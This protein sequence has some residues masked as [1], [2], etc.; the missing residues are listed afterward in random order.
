MDINP[1]NFKNIDGRSILLIG[2]LGNIGKYITDVL[3]QL[4]NYSFL[5]LMDVKTPQEEFK[6][7][8]RNIEAC[9]GAELGNIKNRDLIKASLDGIDTVLFAVGI[10][11]RLGLTKDEKTSL[12][13]TELVGIKNIIESQGREWNV[14]EIIYISSLGAGDTYPVGENTKIKQ[15]VDEILKDEVW[16]RR[17]KTFVSIRPSGYLYDIFEMPRELKKRKMPAYLPKGGE[18]YIQPIAEENVAEMIVRSINNENARNNYIHAAGP[19]KYTYRELFTEFNKV[20]GYKFTIDGTVD[21]GFCIEW[22]GSDVIAH[23]L[24]THSIITDKQ[25]NDLT[26]KYFPGIKLITLEEAVKKHPEYIKIN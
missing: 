12:Y 6:I 9:F 21:A 4:Q 23:R 19:K 2:A 7:P 18:V 20:F 11:P 24:N 17:R 10:R 5:R 26:E 8:N 22:Y 1:E 25:L 3:L 13:E 15:K 14:N 16:D